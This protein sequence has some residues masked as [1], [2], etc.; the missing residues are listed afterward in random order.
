[1]SRTVPEGTKPTGRT[2]NQ[3]GSTVRLPD[4]P[5]APY[6]RGEHR[7]AGRMGPRS[8]PAIFR[9]LLAATDLRRSRAFYESLL[10]TRGRSVAPGR[11]YFDCGPV[12]L[13]ILDYS[14]APARDLPESAES[15]YLSTRDL[16]GV[17]ERAHRLGCLDPGLIHNDPSSPAGAPVVRPWGERS[18]YCHDPSGNSLCFVE[19]ST[20]F[21]G[22]PRQIAALKGATA[23]NRR[24]PPRYRERSTTLPR[25]SAVRKHRT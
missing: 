24:R 7:V 10:G 14:E 3:T 8:T 11:V 18:F 4:V 22:T 21:T 25:R 2:L 12:I 6:S 19:D 9:V 16:E 23:T 15:I 20:K 17:H 1:V 13:G 5:Q